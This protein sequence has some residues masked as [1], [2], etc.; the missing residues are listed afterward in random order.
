MNQAYN[1]KLIEMGR[2]VD[3]LMEYNVG[4]YVQSYKYVSTW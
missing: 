2:F 1:T 4:V 3:T